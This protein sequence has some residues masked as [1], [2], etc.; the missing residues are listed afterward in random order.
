LPATH[1]I[2]IAAMLGQAN[3]LAAAGDLAGARSVFDR[4]G[5][6]AEQCA[7]LGLEPAMKRSGASDS[8]YPMAALKFGFEGWVRAEYDIGPD[9]RTIAPRA[10]IAYPPFIFEDAATGIVRDT[11]YI[12]TFRP[13][14]ALACSG[15]QMSI[16][17]IIP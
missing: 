5:L 6:T 11:R 1:P 10:V 2:K 15:E 4:T 14:G 13:E 3:V 17:F 9:G 12:S 7:T 16:R 8:D